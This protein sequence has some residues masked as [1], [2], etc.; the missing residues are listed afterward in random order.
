M[1]HPSTKLEFI[2]Q[3]KGFGVFAKEFI[4]EGTI[5]WVKDQLD[6]EL[7][8]DEVIN[9]GKEYV[10]IFETYSSQNHL[11]NYILRW[12]I[13][14]YVNQHSQSN[15]LSTPYNFTIA[16][17]NIE[18]GEELTEDYG[19]IQ[20]PELT[21]M[22]KMRNIGKES[23]K[24]HLNNAPPILDDRLQQV[25]PK[26]MDNEQLLQPYFSPEMKECIDKIKLEQLELKR[27]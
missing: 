1:I 10:S 27:N 9:L 16:I 5:T 23:S 12:D 24:N 18:K 11:G 25:F 15:C 21:E 22:L 7:S 14:K 6:K 17:R 8:Y 13:G 26:I 3:T 2:N 20:F 19:R 4:P